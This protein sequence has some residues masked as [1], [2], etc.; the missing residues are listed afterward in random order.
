MSPSRERK[1]ISLRGLFGGMSMFVIE[2]LIVAVFAAVAFL[3]STFF[4]LLI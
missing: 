2:G 1:F 4:L 3:L